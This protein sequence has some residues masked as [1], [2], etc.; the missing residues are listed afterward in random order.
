MSETS[1]REKHLEIFFHKFDFECFGDL[2]WQLVG[3]LSQL[4]KLRVLRK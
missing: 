3:D 4:Q 2:S 1:N